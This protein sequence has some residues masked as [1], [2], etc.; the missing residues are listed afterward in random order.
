VSYS[1]LQAGKP[2]TDAEEVLLQVER[3]LKDAE[4]SSPIGLAWLRTEG[5]LIV[6]MVPALLQN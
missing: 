6:R 5:E 4:I 3:A 2:V 1:L